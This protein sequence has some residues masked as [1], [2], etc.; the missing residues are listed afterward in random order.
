[1]YI[2]ILSTKNMVVEIGLNR[3]IMQKTGL[4]SDYQE[5]SAKQNKTNKNFPTQLLTTIYTIF[6]IQNWQQFYEKMWNTPKPVFTVF[7]VF[8]T[9]RDIFLSCGHTHTHILFSFWKHLHIN[10]RRHTG[11]LN[12]NNGCLRVLPWKKKCLPHV[13]ISPK[14]SDVK[15]EF[16]GDAVPHARVD[17][18]RPQR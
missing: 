10:T 5:K 13:H 17:A 14:Q 18:D 16:A 4:G 11:A 2:Q 15:R 7:F 1:M 8:S 3:K 6:P 12:N 9:L